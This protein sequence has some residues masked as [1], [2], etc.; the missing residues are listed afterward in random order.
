MDSKKEYPIEQANIQL[1][2]AKIRRDKAMKKRYMVM[3]MIGFTPTV[4]MILYFA[5]SVMLS[6]PI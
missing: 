2:A 6:K 3:F 1:E 4:L 5:V